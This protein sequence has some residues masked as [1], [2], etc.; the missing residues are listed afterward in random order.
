MEPIIQLHRDHERLLCAIETVRA[1][2]WAEHREDAPACEIA[3]RQMDLLMRA[4]DDLHHWA[5]RRVFRKLCFLLGSDVR[6]IMDLSEDHERLRRLRCDAASAFHRLKESRR[7]GALERA[8]LDRFLE[9]V[10]AQMATEEGA[11]F[12]LAATR[13]GPSDWAEIGRDVGE[14]QNALALAGAPAEKRA[15]CAAADQTLIAAGRAERPGSFR[16][17]V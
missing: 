1:Q 10:E 3:A 17:Y 13:L 16:P 14:L 11:L 15:I 8:A 4:P 12:D 6:S 5:E 7:L 9:A 2:L